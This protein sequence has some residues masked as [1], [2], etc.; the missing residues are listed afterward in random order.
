M[1]KPGASAGDMAALQ[2]ELMIKVR[3]IVA[4]HGADFAFPTQTLD[5]P[6]PIETVTKTDSR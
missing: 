2:Q 4:G 5:I 6:A 3:E 1:T